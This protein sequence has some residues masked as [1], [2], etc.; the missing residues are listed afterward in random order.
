M[1][2]LP[3]YQDCDD[4]GT[5]FALSDLN[6]TSVLLS[7]RP[8]EGIPLTNCTYSTEADLRKYITTFYMPHA[9]SAELDELMQLYPQDPTQGSPFGTGDFNELSPQFKRLAALLGDLVSGPKTIL[10]CKSIREAE[11]V[12]V[13]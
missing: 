8:H 13:Q 9:T 3:N 10:P 7:A 1:T 12:V 2:L 4:E 11:H 5:L 6:I